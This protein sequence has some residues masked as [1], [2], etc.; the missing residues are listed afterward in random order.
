M[1]V[2]EFPGIAC[3]FQKLVPGS[4]STGVDTAYLMPQGNYALRF[5]SGGVGTPNAGD[6]LTGATSGAKAVVRQRVLESGTWAGGNAVGVLICDYV[7]GTFQAENL[8]C[9]GILTQ[10]DVCTI[11]A[12]CFWPVYPAKDKP[13][14]AMLVSAEDNSAVF[15]LNGEPPTQS[16]GTKIGHELAD[17][18][19]ILLKG[20]D[21]IGK[22]RCMDYTAA[23]ATT[24]KCTLFY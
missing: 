19:S 8:N 20:P 12:G 5:T 17:T 21:A 4:T 1:R 3:F 13:P 10:S 22:F 15:T 6:L 23:T 24:V 16:G 11:A 18:A 7:S 9:S 14:V 2:M